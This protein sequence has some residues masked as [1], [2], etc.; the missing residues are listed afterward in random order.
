MNEEEG[1]NSK[2]LK[3]EENLK[4]YM[5]KSE[6]LYENDRGKRKFFLR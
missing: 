3:E 4:N 2:E 5:R 6:K 1:Q